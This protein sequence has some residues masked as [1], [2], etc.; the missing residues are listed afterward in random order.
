MD[1]FKLLFFF[2]S[3]ALTLQLGCLPLYKLFHARLLRKQSPMQLSEVLNDPAVLSA[4]RLSAEKT[5]ATSKKKDG[6]G[7]H[8]LEKKGTDK[9]PRPSDGTKYWANAREKVQAELSA[10]M[11]GLGY[12]GFILPW[13]DDKS[14]VVARGNT[15]KT[16]WM[17]LWS[18]HLHG[19]VIV[20]SSLDMKVGFMGILSV[21]I[22][23]RVVFNSGCIPA[24]SGYHSGLDFR[25]KTLRKIWHDVG[26]VEGPDMVIRYQDYLRRRHIAQLQRS[27]KHRGDKNDC[28]R[29]AEGG[30]PGD[31][32]EELV[33]SALSELA[34]SCSQKKQK[35][36]EDCITLTVPSL[37]SPAA[38]A[39]QVAQTLQ[40]WPRPVLSIVQ[41]TTV[42]VQRMVM[43]Q[44][45]TPPTQTPIVAEDHLLAEARGCVEKTKA[46][47]VS[48]H[49]AF[50]AASAH[51]ERLRA[52]RQPGN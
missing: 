31:P 41:P 35:K 28:K 49:Q 2:K 43:I 4:F 24:P 52:E 17:K 16:L 34:S 29:K 11:V 25:E 5:D 47:F 48:A 22:L 27:D 15:A 3:R 26:L 45:P 14:G 1:F 8:W 50:L 18:D 42:Q 40:A 9:E 12:H 23:N 38:A 21:Q 32:D 33:V 51:Y 13:H 7:M 39:H 44:Q 30:K 6:R 20:E 10:A 46:N 19:I 36:Q 37:I